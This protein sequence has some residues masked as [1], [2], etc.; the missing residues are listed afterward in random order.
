MMSASFFAYFLSGATER[1]YAARRGGTR[2][3][4]RAAISSKLKEKT[5]AR[6]G[7]INPHP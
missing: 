4:A 3:A 2:L 1:K 5:A 6:A 7:P